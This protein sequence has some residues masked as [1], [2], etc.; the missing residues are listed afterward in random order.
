MRERER[1]RENSKNEERRKVAEAWPEEE[2]LEAI[3]E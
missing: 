2:W 1:E 3:I